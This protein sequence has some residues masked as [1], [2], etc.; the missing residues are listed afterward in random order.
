ME[1]EDWLCV[2]EWVCKVQEKFFSVW[3]VGVEL[4]REREKMRC[5]QILGEF[6]IP[7]SSSSS[8]KLTRG[9]Q[10]YLYILYVPIV[11]WRNLLKSSS[12]SFLLPLDY[13]HCQNFFTNGMVFLLVRLKISAPNYYCTLVV[14]SLYHYCLSLSFRFSF[15]TP[16][17]SIVVLF[18]D[19][20]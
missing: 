7:S 9:T 1:N 10:P 13:R 3:R 20:T 19:R 15:S 12:T 8:S 2:S 4:Q 6:I 5:R 16:F 14:F 18:H 17:G 11:K